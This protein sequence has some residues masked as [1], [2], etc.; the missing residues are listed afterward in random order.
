MAQMV[1][2]TKK[3]Q[4]K[5]SQALINKIMQLNELKD[6]GKINEVEYTRLRQKAIRRYKG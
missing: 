5:Q 3:L 2:S 6:S 1:K 4:K